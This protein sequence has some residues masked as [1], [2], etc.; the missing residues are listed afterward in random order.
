MNH[1]SDML[2][3]CSAGF[4]CAPTFRGN[5]CSQ[6]CGLLL[7]TSDKRRLTPASSTMAAAAQRRRGRSSRGGEL[8]HLPL[9]HVDL[10]RAAKWVCDR[11]V[12]A[13]QLCYC[14]PQSLQCRRVAQPD[15]AGFLLQGPD[16]DSRDAT[17]AAVHAERPIIAA[18]EA[19]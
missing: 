4:L 16:S 19:E 17:S 15:S 13:T 9:R 7:Q 2:F 14:F 12:G 6:S 3:C 11:R 18:E 1:S 5:N 8:D 10:T